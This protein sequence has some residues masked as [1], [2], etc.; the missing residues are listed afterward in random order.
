VISKRCH[1]DGCSKQS[2]FAPN[3]S[4]PISCKVHAEPGWVD[5]KNKRCHRDGCGKRAAFG[6]KGSRPISCKAHAEPG[7]VDVTNKNRKRRHQ[8]SAATDSN[9]RQ[10]TVDHGMGVSTDAF[11]ELA[12]LCDRLEHRV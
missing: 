1:H 5:V 4:K 2:N 6:P 3:G 11:L 7:W 8:H 12:N 10:R 9:K